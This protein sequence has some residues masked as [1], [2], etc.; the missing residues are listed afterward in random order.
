MLPV[1][2]FPLCIHDRP[3]YL[4]RALHSTHTAHCVYKLTLCVCTAH[5]VYTLHTPRA[6]VR[7]LIAQ[8]VERVAS[9]HVVVAATEHAV[10]RRVTDAVA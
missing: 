1:M 3:A 2:T 8:R 4:W 9:E 10:V 5:C 7:R 6:T